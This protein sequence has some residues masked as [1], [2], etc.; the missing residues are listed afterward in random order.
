MKCASLFLLLVSI[1]G[2]LFP[3][4]SRAAELPFEVRRAVVWVLC[5]NRQGSGV[6]IQPNSGYV[7]TNAHVA[8]NL[9]NGKRGPCRVGLISDAD[10]EPEIYFDATVVEAVFDEETNRDFAILK[11]GEQKNGALVSPLPSLK[12]DEFS[13]VG[14][15]LS[16]VSYPATADGK[17]IVTN[18]TIL[19][20][21]QGTVRTDAALSS[22]SSG[23]PAL[24]GNHDL[25]GIA[26]GIRYTITDDGLEEILDYQ[27]V[28]VRALLTWLDTL[29]TNAHDQYI[30]HRD[31]DRYH[32]PSGFFT[33]SSLSCSILARLADDSAVYCLKPNGTRTVF[34]DAQ[35]FRS[36][37]G[38]FSPVEVVGSTDLANARLVGV[39]T[40]KPGSLIKIESDP[41]VYL[42]TD[43]MGT[44][45]WIPTE[46]T[47]KELFGEGW[48]GFVR[49]IPVSFFPLYK[50]GPPLPE[51]ITN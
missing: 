12:T 46:E 29:G 28:D 27:L 49:D 10:Y 48:A 26:M 1:S 40:S 45:R 32:G 6:I 47:A 31:S 37:F 23:G 19:A 14:D 17:Q 2:T 3:T 33:T 30:V 25:I 16:V 43:D 22:G 13:R 36:W 24:N 18:G 4:I 35:T 42:V 7:L 50:I 21:E 5:G 9:T 8:T 38:D 44:L 51:D 20:L 39:V 41:K 15:A 11:L 34:P